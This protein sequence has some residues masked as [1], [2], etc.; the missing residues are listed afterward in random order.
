MAEIEPTQRDRH[1]QH[2]AAPGRMGWRKLSWYDRRQS[3]GCDRELEAGD[4]RRAALAH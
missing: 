4:R 1:L 3:R 2:I